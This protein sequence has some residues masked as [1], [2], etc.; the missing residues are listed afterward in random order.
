M[1]IFAPGLN[2]A[3]RT[4]PLAV[5]TVLGGLAN[6]AL[7]FALVEPLGIEGAALSFL[8]TQAAAFA[9][10]M[11]LSQRLYPAPHQWGRLA[12]G[13][14]IGAALTLGGWLLPPIGDDLW[15]LPAKLGVAL[16]AVGVFAALLMDADE[17]AMGRDGLR[18]LRP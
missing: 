14:V 15:A 6:L 7:A 13:L 2:I 9:T 18:S 5:V 10:L 12:V 4:R 11:W 8:V 1:Y 16:L 3:K 17:R